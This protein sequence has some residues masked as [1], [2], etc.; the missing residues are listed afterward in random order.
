M[1]LPYKV[2]GSCKP[3]SLDYLP[4]GAIT[5][6]VGLALYQS[7]GLLALASGTN[8]PTYICM[9]EGPTLTS[10]DVIPVL[11][12]TEDRVFETEFSA[13]GTSINLGAKVTIA[14]DGLRVTATTT[15]GVA[16]VVA[17]EG[18]GAT[19]DKVLVRFP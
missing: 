3:Q 17:K 15:N 7:S 4:A 8:K 19:G 2:D 14:S 9:T 12:V 10:G 6:K 5:P 18:T 1:F 13:S 11:R 16:E